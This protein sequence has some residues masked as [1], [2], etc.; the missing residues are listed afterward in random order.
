MLG[1]KP[2][3]RLSLYLFLILFTPQTLSQADDIRD[4]QIEGMS[5]GDSAL[6]FFTKSEIK[7]N[8]QA[9]W[10]NKTYVQFCT[11]K[12]NYNNYENV[13]FV[14]LKKD[15]KYIIEQLSGEIYLAFN[16]CIKKQKEIVLEI[17]GLF[18]SAEKNVRK[19]K[20][21]ADKKGKS[22]VRSVDF[23]LKDG[24]ALAVGCTDWSDR[25]TKKEGWTDYVGV[26]LASQ[27]FIEWNKTKAFK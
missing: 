21:R 26:F 15:K 18:E 19:T 6:D 1:N 16:D 13:C 12:G 17:E 24:S 20:H 22:I 9:P 8:T 25:L 11:E 3:K 7:K 10:P 23:Y 14:Y 4:F 2:M 5:I 27:K